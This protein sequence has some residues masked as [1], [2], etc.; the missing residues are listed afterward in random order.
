MPHFHPIVFSGLTFKKELEARNLRRSRWTSFKAAAS[1][2]RCNPAHPRVAGS[3]P[4][5]SAP[6][7]RPDPGD[8]PRRE[9]PASCALRPGDGRSTWSGRVARAAA[10]AQ[11]S[12]A[13][14]WKVSLQP[15]SFQGVFEKLNQARSRE[16]SFWISVLLLFIFVKIV[17]AC[18]FSYISHLSSPPAPHH[19]TLES[20]NFSAIY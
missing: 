14:R 1:Q 6:T 12:P 15:S 10:P 2:R 3:C 18:R 5:Q 17:F 13:A 20:G 8:S 4:F 11:S 16:S 9:S 7:R 19:L